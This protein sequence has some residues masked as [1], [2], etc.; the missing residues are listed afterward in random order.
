MNKKKNK[1]E[2][3]LDVMEQLRETTMQV[4]DGKIGLSTANSI[5]NGCGKIAGSAKGII[6]Y[7]KMVKT[8]GTISYWEAGIEK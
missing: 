2:N 4:R 8:R 7:Q 3:V 6:E 1:L 5:F